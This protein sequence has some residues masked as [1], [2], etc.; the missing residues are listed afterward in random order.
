MIVPRGDR[1][2]VMGVLNVTPDS[3]SDGGRWVDADAAV[4]HGLALVA[5]GADVVDVGG[6]SSRPGAEPVEE[7]VEIARVV[8]VIE[9]LAH[10][11]RV[12]VDTVKPAVARAAAAAGATLLNDIT[13]SQ[14]EV[15]AELGLGWVAM[16]MQGDPRTMQQAPHY[17]DVVAEV[18]GFLAERAAAAIDA[19]VAE[20]WID[21]GIGFGK[22]QAHNLSLLRHLDRVVA[23]GHPV[24]V[25]TSRKSTIG[26]IL[27]DSDDV[28][29]PVPV[30]DRVEGSIATATWAFAAGVAMVRAHDVR[31]TVQAALVVGRP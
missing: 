8:P 15:A 25:G 9:V 24:L 6:E 23:T 31:P 22:T 4:A 7:A 30:G 13:A 26:R 17:G 19:G 3:F 29:E 12:S 14:H 27:A 1:A 20:V 28:A 16:H 21:P 10:H 5:D 18:S 2:L 11:V